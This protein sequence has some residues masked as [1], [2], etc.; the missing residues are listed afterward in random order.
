MADTN[1][2]VADVA[3]HAPAI[4]ERLGA[5]IPKVFPTPIADAIRSGLRAP[6][7]RLYSELPGKVQAAGAR[8]EV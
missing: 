7:V 1:E 6:S 2:I 5:A 3:T 4:I 8:C